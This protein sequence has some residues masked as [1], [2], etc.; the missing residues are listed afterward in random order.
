MPLSHA[1]K[2]GFVSSHIE[3]L[4]GRA[5]FYSGLMAGLLV[6]YLIPDALHEYV[7]ST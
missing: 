4:A 1:N 3:Y 2:S 6:N 5:V 7:R